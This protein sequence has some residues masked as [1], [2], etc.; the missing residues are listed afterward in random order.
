VPDLPVAA[1]AERLGVPLSASLLTLA[2]THRSYAFEHGGLPTNERLEFLGDS[3]LGLV[4]TDALYRRYPDESEGQL[5][6]S[7]SG[8]VSAVALADTARTLGLGD[9]LL[10]G[11][12]EERTGGRD[13]ASI[14]A[15]ALEA[16]IGAVYLEHG[17][18]VTSQ[19]VMRMVAPRLDR[20]TT[21]GSGTDWKTCLQ[22]ALASRT[23]STLEYR[24]TGTGPDHARS[25][26]A[27]AVVDGQIWGTGHGP[28]KKQA[29][30]QAAQQAC[31]SL[32]LPAS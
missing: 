2:L 27:D 12:G 32:G 31:A 6:K 16:V 22:E 21:P 18:D 26:S 30:Q 3:V 19:V 28:S 24:V 13:K 11:N 8:I 14:L 4:V 10:L 20:A 23:G 7:R 9:W 15:D 5:A 29:E 17:F 1:L 25:Y